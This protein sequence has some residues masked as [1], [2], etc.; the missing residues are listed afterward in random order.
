MT[1]TPALFDV[2]EPAYATPNS[3]VAVQALV[4]VE[5]HVSFAGLP[6]MTDDGVAVSVTAG[7][8]D[9]AVTNESHAIGFIAP[10]RQYNVPSGAEGVPPSPPHPVLPFMPCAQGI[11]GGFVPASYANP[12]KQAPDEVTANEVA[13]AAPVI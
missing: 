10:L 3:F 1:E 7:A 5:T 6:D 9:C 8:L 11:H 12:L 4:L 2:A 13:G